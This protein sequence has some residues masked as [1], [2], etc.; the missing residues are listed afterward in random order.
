MLTTLPS[1]LRQCCV[2][3]GCARLFSILFCRK[4][5]TWGRVPY[6][7]V[8][9]KHTR[10]RVPR[11]QDLLAGF[12]GWGIFGVR[13]WVCVT[14]CPVTTR[15]TG[16]LGWAVIPLGRSH[17]A[18][19]FCRAH[20]GNWSSLLVIKTHERESSISSALPNGTWPAVLWTSRIS[21]HKTV[22][23]TALIVAGWLTDLFY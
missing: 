1:G 9:K 8:W 13:L 2:H 23:R 22:C 11:W 6:F 19:I 4:K 3:Q 20:V 12:G 7:F 16:G 10:G 18:P 14:I 17:T 21:S 15:L 5:R